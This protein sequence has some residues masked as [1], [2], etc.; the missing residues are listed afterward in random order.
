MD[1]KKTWYQSKTLWANMAAL[2]GAL[3]GAM[4][5]DIS[6]SEAIPVIVIAVVNMG[7]RL[8]TNRGIA[9]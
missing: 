3:G 8:I 1:E 4:Q 7:L 9:T 5:G 6:W 2:M